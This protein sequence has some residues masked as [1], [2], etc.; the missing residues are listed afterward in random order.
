ML[1]KLKS[2]FRKNFGNYL[3]I[4]EGQS[5][6]RKKIKSLCTTVLQGKKQ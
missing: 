5:R 2:K 6:L 1:V 3:H 4:L